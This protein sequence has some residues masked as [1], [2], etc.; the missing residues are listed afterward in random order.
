[1]FKISAGFEPCGFAVNML[2]SCVGCE[3]SLGAVLLTLQAAKLK[4]PEYF[5]E[6]TNDFM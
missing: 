6:C 1:M 5:F 3:D 2:V 4:T